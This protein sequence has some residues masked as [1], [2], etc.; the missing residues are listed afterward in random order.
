[1]DFCGF[2]DEKR[3]VLVV[4]DEAGHVGTLG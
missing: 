2:E 4:R 3:G 1:V